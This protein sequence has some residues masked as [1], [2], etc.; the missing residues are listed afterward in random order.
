MKHLFTWQSVVLAAAVGTAACGGGAS[1]STQPAGGSGT[2]TAGGPVQ[3]MEYPEP[4]FPAYLKP[5]SS[6]EE[7]M[8][9]ARRLAQNRRGLQGAG[10]GIIEKGDTVLWVASTEAE[11]VVL[12]ALKRA[13]E[14]R[15]GM[16]IVK[17]DYEM[18][19]VPREEALAFKQDAAAIRRVPRSYTSEFGFKEAGNWVDAQFPDPAAAKAWL[20]QR[21]PDLHDQLFPQSEDMTPRQREI[22]EKFRGENLGAAIR[23]YLDQHPDIR[24]VFWG[25]GGSTFLR[26]Y[27]RPSENK[28]LGL[29]VIENRWDLMSQLGTYPGDVW[30]LAE[31][32]TMEPIV[33]VDRIDI[34]DPEGTNL[35]TDITEEMARNW[36]RGVY[37][38][39]HLY[40]FPNQATGRFGYS[41]VDY[42]AFQHEWLPRE[43][44]ALANGTIGG[45]VNHTGFFPRWEIAVKDGYVRG[46]SGGG[47]FGEAL[48][49]F[50]QYPNSNDKV[51]PYHQPN[52][53]GYWWLYE[54]A[55]G[56]HP[57][58]FRNPSNL[59]QGSALVERNRAGVF[60]WGIGVTLHHDPGQRDKSQKLLDFTGQYNLPRDHGWHTHTYF[61]TYRVHLRNADRTIALVDKGRLASLDNPE[62]RALASRYG[63]PADLLQE[64]WRPNIPGVNL[65]GRYEDYA[66]NP[67]RHVKGALDEVTAGTYRFFFPPPATSAQGTED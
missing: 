5:P 21:R 48:R 65:P 13:V 38:R 37:Q 42:P 33:H 10:F 1:R 34:R 22:Y 15:G 8:P 18:A 11:D 12:D 53:P 24:G 6:A 45:T 23:T 56:T 32:Q 36:A 35:T 59:S 40:M 57:K 61:T 4:R 44:M 30:Q 46:V 41:V 62:V 67:W 27:L 60:H 50:L 54:I 25:F 16:V 51:F 17:R 52:H 9:Y 20:K 26:R 7:L 47:L 29:F 14:E 64:D 19:D 28:L 55:L 31:E 43:P 58:G 63:D 49:E 39:G 3:K 2:S 66:A